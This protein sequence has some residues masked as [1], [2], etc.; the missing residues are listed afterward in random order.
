VFAGYRRHEMDNMRKT[1]ALGRPEERVAVVEHLVAKEKLAEAL[2]DQP[3]WVQDHVIEAVA[4]LGTPEALFQLT[5][6]VYLLDAPTAARAKEVLTRFDLMA[7]GPLVKALKDKD[8]NVR[9]GATDPLVAIGAPV[10]PS[11]LPLMDAWDKYVRDGVVTVFG[12]IGAPVTDEMIAIIKRTEPL[13]DETAQRFL[14]KR[15]TAVRAMLAMKVP[16]IEPIIKELISYKEAEVRALAAQMLGQIADQ[17]VA[18]P[19]DAEDAAVVVRPLLDRLNNDPAWTVRRKAAVA[20]GALGDVGKEGGAVAALIAHLHDARPEVKAASAEA[21]GRLGDPAA[22]GPLV[23]TLLTNRFGAVREIVVA[24]ERL[25]P[26]ALPAIL[27]ALTSSDLEVRKAATEAVAVIGTS[28]AVVPLANMLKD[29][30]VTIRRLASDALR[31]LADQRVVPQLVGA[32]ADP[33]WHVYY[34]ARDA[35]ANV[36]GAAVPGLV[37]ALGSGNPRVAHMAEQALSEIGKPA[38]LPLTAALA[39]EKEQVR[40]WAAVALGDIGGPAVKPVIVVLTDLSRPVYARAAAADALGRTG[41]PA[42]VD[43]LIAAAA[44]QEP[45]VQI[46]ALRSLV[47]LGDEKATDALVKALQASSPQVRSVATRLLIDW[48]A[49]DISQKL[50]QAM[51]Q[52]DKDAQRRAG[53]ALAFHAAGV[54]HKL[55]GDA[56]AVLG[57]KIQIPPGLEQMLVEAVTD[58]SEPGDVKKLAVEGL[59]YVGREKAVSSLKTLLQTEGPLAFRAAKAIALIGKRI[60]EERYR[61]G[62]MEEVSYRKR[63]PTQAAQV[64]L[65]LLMNAK[66]D[67]LRLYAAVGLSMMGDDPVPG[68]LKALDTAPDEKRVWLVAVLGAIGKPASDACLD[69]RGT[70]ENPQVK[71]W[72][73]VAIRLIGDAQAMDL[74]DHLG[75]EE[76]PDP[77][78]VKA[79]MEIKERIIK[80]RSAT[81]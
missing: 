16:A 60:V 50:S 56:A 39:S 3:R 62:Q 71:E 65:D 59:G 28:G 51:N 19:I 77:Q 34:A 12:K 46:A 8:A 69:A 76:Q 54:A 79:G 38:V 7:I 37:A 6:S 48:S 64:L 31:T 81:P 15:D 74:L 67:T 43:P 68:L 22:A 53:I 72:I 26:K 5:G 17:T 18:T 27:P 52:G 20:L 73:T 25:G 40:R 11:L 80:E 14:W 55:V 33:D 23:N 63:Q 32:L 41:S 61:A 10:I 45:V 57:Q 42:G 70:A 75:K 9:S 30:D 2:Q 1:V 66:D 78:H 29:P 21:L 35:L 58:P 36:G 47:R 49:T 44:K 13:P 4:E 24:L